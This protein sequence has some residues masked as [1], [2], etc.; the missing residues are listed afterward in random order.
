M[1]LIYRG[2]PLEFPDSDK[3]KL[4]R[5]GEGRFPFFPGSNKNTHKM[6]EHPKQ[7]GLHWTG[8]ERG[9][10]GVVDTLTKRDLSIHSVIENDG[11]I[12][13]TADL[14]T[15]CAHIGRPSNWH[16]FGIEIT[17]RGFASKKDL[18]G[19][20]LRDRVDLDWSEPR[21]VYTDTIGGRKGRMVS[22]YPDQLEST[23]WYVETLCGLFG[24]PRQIPYQVI[25][26]REKEAVRFSDLLVLHNEQFVYPLF[27]R[28]TRRTRK[29]RR[30]SF[31]GVIG[32]FHVH[33]D[34]WD[35]GTQIFYK[36]WVEGFNPAHKKLPNAKWDG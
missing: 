2:K 29:G 13:Q 6:K 14:E 30:G 16:S 22:F 28:D 27:D 32:H 23:L 9:V 15:M 19:S 36:L 3:I 21:D 34:K 18:Q 1:P 5:D 12:W 31:E 17:S 25:T 26:G 35:P 8:G 24:I 4:Y 11:D 7:I 20:S 10:P 33:P